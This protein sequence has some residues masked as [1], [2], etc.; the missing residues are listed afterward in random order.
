[1][2]GKRGI[3]RLKH[4]IFVFFFEVKNPFKQAGHFDMVVHIK[5][6]VKNLSAQLYRYTPQR[7][8]I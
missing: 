2:Q 5:K 1:M 8:V 4:T 3:E 7:I 6:A